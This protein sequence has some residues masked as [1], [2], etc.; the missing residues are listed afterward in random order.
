MSAD[1]SQRKEVVAIA[2]LALIASF[3]L[4][5]SPARA[6]EP[7]IGIPPVMGV[8]EEIGAAAHARLVNELKK[9]S[10]S[11]ATSPSDAFDYVLRGYF[12]ISSGSRLASFLWELN[13]R[14]GKRVTSILVKQPL[15][16]IKH[17]DQLPKNAPEVIDEIAR[18]SAAKLADW[19]AS[20]ALSDAATHE[21]DVPTELSKS[22]TSTSLERTAEYNDRNA[23]RCLE[24]VSR[25]NEPT[26]ARILGAEEARNMLNTFAPSFSVSNVCNRLTNT[27]AQ[28]HVDCFE[29]RLPSYMAN[30]K[31]ADSVKL[32]ECT[33]ITPDPKKS[34]FC[35]CDNIVNRVDANGQLLPV[36]FAVGLVP[37]PSTARLKDFS[38]LAT[39]TLEDD[40]FRNIE[41]E[42]SSDHSHF[43][44]FA[45]RATNQYIVIRSLDAIYSFDHAV[46]LAKDLYLPDRFSALAGL[47]EKKPLK[48]LKL[49]VARRIGS[50]NPLSMPGTVTVFGAKSVESAWDKSK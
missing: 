2:V 12:N 39:I 23:E 14:S 46:T 5:S 47:K 32:P 40:D 19:L 13:D 20:N 11:L 8:P 21:A 30:L 9:G 42:V 22:E 31:K 6:R 7:T 38:V 44:L 15:P 43:D 34:D 27:H 50:G 37:A 18:S 36:K 33:G 35:L 4:I 41:I 25:A 45:V 26:L 1:L 48:G 28:S 29:M 3:T 10:V 16:N 17:D 49:S 24:L